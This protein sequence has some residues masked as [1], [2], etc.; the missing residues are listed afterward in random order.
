MS[1]VEPNHKPGLCT[2]KGT[3]TVKFKDQAEY[4]RF[5]EAF[6]TPRK[7][8]PFLGLALSLVVWVAIITL[9][10]WIV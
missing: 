5:A 3:F 9:I 10:V 8:G 6:N 4:D 7:G 1:S 2:F